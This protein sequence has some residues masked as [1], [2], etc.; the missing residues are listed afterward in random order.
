MLTVPRALISETIEIIA[1]LAGRGAERRLVDLAHVEGLD[2]QGDYRL[3]SLSTLV[4]GDV[5]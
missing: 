1:V 4:N 5:P 2:P 3:T